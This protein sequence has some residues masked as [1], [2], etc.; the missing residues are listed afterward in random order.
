MKMLK[1]P[2][3]GSDKLSIVHKNCAKKKPW[4]RWT[5]MTFSVRCNV[6]HAR[7]PAFS[8]FIYDEEKTKAIE[9]AET[10]A[11]EKWNMRADEDNNSV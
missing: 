11:C 3:C 9:E 5:E 4:L 7:G 8:K 1:C 2:F 6:C 10:A